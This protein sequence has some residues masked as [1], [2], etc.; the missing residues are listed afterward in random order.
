[1]E[2]ETIN[3]EEKKTNKKVFTGIV[4]S[5]KMEKTRVVSVER[6]LQHPVYSK[7]VRKRKKFKVHDE[8]NK[9]RQ[10]DVVEIIE[11]RPISKEKRWRLVQIIKEAA[12]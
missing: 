5:D 3:V 9:S 7:Y 10:G 2:M 4:V 11:C 12:K 1:M 6:K 8:E